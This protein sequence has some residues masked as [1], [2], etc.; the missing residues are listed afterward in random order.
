MLN[1]RLQTVAREAEAERLSLG[2][3]SSS[4][5]AAALSA[6]SKAKVELAARDR[7]IARLTADLETYS[8][9]HAGLTARLE[10]SVIV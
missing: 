4:S 8:H 1:L 6:A 9:R 2:S 10:Q 5:A 3:T 7:E